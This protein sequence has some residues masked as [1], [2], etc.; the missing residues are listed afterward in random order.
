MT[1]QK[2]LRHFR[3]RALGA[4]HNG[5]GTSGQQASRDGK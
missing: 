5:L 1:G 4:L 3:V 2:M